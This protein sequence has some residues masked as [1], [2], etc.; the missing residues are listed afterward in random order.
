[1]TTPELIRQYQNKNLPNSVLIERAEKQAGFIMGG[2]VV[3]MA[4][5]TLLAILHCKNVMDK[6]FENGTYT[7]QSEFRRNTVSKPQTH[8]FRT[9]Q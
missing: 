3:L 6:E 9:L 8:F 5:A 2:F 7:Y 1:M 4:I